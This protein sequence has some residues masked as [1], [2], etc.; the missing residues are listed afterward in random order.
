LYQRVSSPL[1]GTYICSWVIYNWEV[2]LPLVFGTKQFDERI[3]DFKVGLYPEATG[4]D[5][6]TVLVP[7]GIT[8]ALLTLQ[9]LLQRFIFIYTE[10]NK[11]EGLKKRDQY[12]SETMLTL[13]QSNELRASVQKVQQFHQEVLKNKEEEVSEYKRQLES[14]DISINSVNDNNLKLIEEN[15]KLENDKSELSVTLATVNGELA[16]L[17]SKYLRLGKLFSKSRK[18]SL[19]KLS[20]IDSDYWSVNTTVLKEFPL[21]VGH[22]STSSEAKR[23][24]YL[25]NMK[26]VSSSPE[27]IFACNEIA[28]D[29][30]SKVW[31]FNMADSYFSELIRPNL[32]TFD[33]TQIHRLINIMEMNGQIRDRNRA[34]ADM[35]LVRATLD[36]RAA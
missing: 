24:N 25:A 10:W 14:K 6:S 18:L 15:T 28:I 36:S 29:G 17:K 35:K 26:N 4:F 8:A 21:L 34:D 11:S 23:A 27:W 33:D 22:D 5:Y 1:Y 32:K 9:P 12:S 2:V 16:D 20:R 19:N 31:S 30:F 7:L 3:S 13:D